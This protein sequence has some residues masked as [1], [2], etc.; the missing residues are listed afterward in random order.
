MNRVRMDLGQTS[1]NHVGQVLQS[2]YTIVLIILEKPLI[3]FI[4][5]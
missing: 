3:L 4:Q 5:M 2:T 1:R